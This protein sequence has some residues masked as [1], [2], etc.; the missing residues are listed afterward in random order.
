MQFYKNKKIEINYKYCYLKHYK[1]EN[2]MNGHKPHGP[3]EAFIKRPLDFFLAFT[4]IICF[5]WLYVIIAIFIRIKLGSPI[6]FS[7]NRPGKD[8]KIF[9][10]YKFRSM[11]NERDENGELLPDEMRLTRFGKILRSTSLD[12][13][14]EV[15]N[16]LKGDMAI[17]GPRPLLTR[18]ISRYSPEQHRRHEVRPGLTGL[19]MSRIRNS[20]GWDKK[21]ELDLEY[22]DNISFLLDIKI[23]FWTIIIVL[24]REGINEEG[25]A[26]NSEFMGENK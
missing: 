8:E 13:L 14:P 16:I 24:K 25:F 18:Y 2:R 21:F 12:E 9:K 1:K 6:L 15:F 11:T 7:Q 22:V 23:I 5:W 3:Y 4:T 26:T 17:I 10:L 19:A 20:A